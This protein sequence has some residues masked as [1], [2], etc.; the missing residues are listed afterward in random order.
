M[1]YIECCVI[2]KGLHITAARNKT[3]GMGLRFLVAF[4][5]DKGCFSL[6]R[7]ISTWEVTINFM[8]DMMIILEQ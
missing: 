1:K 5:N 2:S 8:A 7:D 4:Q 6:L 3:F